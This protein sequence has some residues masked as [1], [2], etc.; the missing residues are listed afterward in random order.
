MR[1][2]PVRRKPSTA[3]TRPSG[4]S[5]SLASSTKRS[6]CGTG[7]R[8]KRHSCASSIVAYGNMERDVKATLVYVWA[9]F[10]KFGTT[11]SASWPRAR[12]EARPEHV[13]AASPPSRASSQQPPPTGVEWRWPIEALQQFGNHVRPGRSASSS[14]GREAVQGGYKT[15]APPDHAAPGTRCSAA[16][17][18]GN[19]LQAVSAEE[20]G[21][22]GAAWPTHGQLR[23]CRRSSTSMRYFVRRK[24]R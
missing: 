5:A 23:R 2:S 19:W 22:I 4:E 9:A 20:L 7:T 8:P 6:T 16:P 3:K 13:E 18:L 1:S 15:T 17:I 21:D 24:R 12:Q 14:N 11:E 10:S